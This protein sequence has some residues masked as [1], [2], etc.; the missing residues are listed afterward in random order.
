MVA[1]NKKQDIALLLARIVVGII[2]LSHATAALRGSNSMPFS[3]VAELG[4]PRWTAH[5]AVWVELGCG[6]LL[7]VGKFTR[8]AAT[9]VAIHMALGVRVHWHQGFLYGSDFPLALVALASIFAAVGPG[10][11]ALDSF[12]KI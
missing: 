7:L 11:Y 12:R 9:L 4:L 5:V 1:M 10:R 3:G 8:I 2:L 6:L